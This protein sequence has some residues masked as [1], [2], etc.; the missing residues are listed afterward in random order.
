M[1]DAMTG[2]ISIAEFAA[3]AGVAPKTVRRRIA[4]G[5]IKAYRMGPRLIRIDPSEA[6]SAFRQI[7]TAGNVA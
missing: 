3:R 6:E 2:G 7:P 1:G 4:D 5:T